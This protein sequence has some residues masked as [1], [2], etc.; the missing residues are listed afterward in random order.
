MAAKLL[1]KKMAELESPG[2]QLSQNVLPGTVNPPDVTSIARPTPNAPGAD[3]SYSLSAAHELANP[4]EAVPVSPS[5][6]FVGTGSVRRDRR[7]RIIGSIA[8]A[9]S[10]EGGKNFHISFADEVEDSLPIAQVHE[11]ECWKEFNAMDGYTEGNSCA[12]VVL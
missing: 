7:S 4:E 2:E 8:C 1:I 12:C 6:N 3:E 11:V 9:N 5:E 10:M